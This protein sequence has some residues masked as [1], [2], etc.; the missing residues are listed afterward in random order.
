MPAEFPISQRF[1]VKLRERVDVIDP[2]FAG[3]P[4]PT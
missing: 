2:T 1:L 4:S 3:P